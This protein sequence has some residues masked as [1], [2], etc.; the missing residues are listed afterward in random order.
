MKKDIWLAIFVAMILVFSSIQPA[1]AAT[2]II[3]VDIDATGS[4]DG[5][6]WEDAYP[7]LQ[8]ALDEA[9]A[10]PGTDIEIWVAEGTYYPDDGPGH[11]QDSRDESFRIQYNNVQLY[12]G[13]A[14]TES[15]REARDWSSNVTILSGDIGTSGTSSDNSY[16][17]LYL[18]GVTNTPINAKTVIDGFTI[19]GGSASG[20]DSNGMWGAV[21]RGQRQR[22]RLQPRSGESDFL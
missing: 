13:F 10:Q 15:I 8:M 11:V 22:A 16:H 1:S 17:V 12:G 4:S 20:S 3:Y 21:L 9:S 6:S 7:L 14:G 18:D 2:T 5:T 19:T